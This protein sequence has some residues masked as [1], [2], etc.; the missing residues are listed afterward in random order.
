MVRAAPS[1]GMMCGVSPAA[2][3]PPLSAPA[4]ETLLQLAPTLQAPLPTLFFQYL[5]AALATVMGD[6]ARTNSVAIR[7]ILTV[8]VVLH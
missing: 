6:K 4:A 7:L 3:A 8:I 1:V 5:L 2:G